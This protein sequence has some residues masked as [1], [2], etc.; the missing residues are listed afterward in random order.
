MRRTSLATRIAVAAVTVATLSGLGTLTAQ[1]DTPAPPAP[2]TAPSS[3]TPADYPEGDLGTAVK[4]FLFSP[5]AVDGANDWNCKPSAEHPEPVVLVH[6]TFFNLGANWPVL[7]PKL[8]NE[9]Y[10]VYAFNYGMNHLSL[11]R[12][13]GLDHIRDSARTMR[14]FVDKVL[15]ATG[16]EQVDVVG[17]SQGGL[18]PHYYIEKL[19]GADKVDEFI[20]MA[21]SNHGTDLSGL[22]SLGRQ[23]NLLGF[24]NGL[25]GRTAPGM[26]DQEV[27]SDFQ[28][29]LFGNGDTVPGPEYTVISTKHDRVVTPYRNQQ[30]DGDNVTNL[31]LQDQC[32]DNPVG[33]AGLFNDSPTHQN[34]LNILGPD[35][36]DFRPTCTGYGLP[37]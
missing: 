9:G 3:S 5:G 19:G 2:A 12:V 31:V 28:R 27:G 11:G 17:H 8:A 37:L 13:G 7:A 22:V 33:H 15:D 36:P 29:E 32:P 25:L 16:S 1:A 30:L 34:I 24:V 26:V 18:L 10:C 14:T 6:G 35:D 23:L 21:P 20:G 4:N